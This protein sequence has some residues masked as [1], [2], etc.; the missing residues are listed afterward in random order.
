MVG[1]GIAG[2][3]V[4]WELAKAGLDVTVL[5]DEESPA[6]TRAAAGLLQV[7]A[8]RL[9]G[10]HLKFRQACQSQYPDFLASLPQSVEIRHR[11]HLKVGGEPAYRAS[12]VAS[13]RGLGLQIEERGDAISMP[14]MSLDPGSLL[15]A[16]E[17][18]LQS[19]RVRR[20]GAR[21]TAWSDGAGRDRAGRAWTADLTVLCCGTGLSSFSQIAWACQKEEGW[22][23]R[24]RGALELPHTVEAAGQ[25]LV[26]HSSQSWRVGGSTAWGQ[27]PPIRLLYPWQGEE[28]ER[29]RGVRCKAPDGLP[30]AGRLEKGLYV[31]GG[32]GR[33]GLL[34]APLLAQG[35]TQEILDGHGPGWLAAFSPGRPRIG[36]KRPWSR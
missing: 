25:T 34:T 19:R 21:L 17:S 14:A 30:V 10:A 11:P 12:F 16:L 15:S 8:G 20:E 2:L 6:A 1:A 28:L 13:L 26:T 31:L 18:A 32:L 3:C 36:E 9:S 24:Y 4:A 29:V 33:N 22:G 27:E 35:L 5:E 7:A 23:A